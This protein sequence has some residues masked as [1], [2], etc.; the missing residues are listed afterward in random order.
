MSSEPVLSKDPTLDVEAAYF[1][2]GAELVIGVDEVGRGAIAGPVAVG[3]YAVLA[4]TREFPVG[5]RD[6]KLLS[7]KRRD[8]LYPLV[9]EWGTGAVGFAS[10]EEIDAHG[11]T[12]ML[13][14][15]ARRA[16]LA[17]H[18]AGVPVE[19]AVIILDGSHDWLSPVLKHP[20]D[21]RT[22]VGADRAC[23]SVAAASVL[24][25]VERD[26]LMRDAHEEHPDY[27]WASNKGYGAKAH[28]E[29]I[30]SAG[31]TELHRTSWIKLPVTAQD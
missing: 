28:Y 21:V 18:H 12:A 16:L 2:A 3:A 8:A 31:L 29:G 6:S 19:R 24:A 17:L 20:L 4:G 1:A 13:A 22:R 25:K 15:A 14:A 7:E 5:L 27:A 30:A 9:R 11:I 10:A 23:A 26:L